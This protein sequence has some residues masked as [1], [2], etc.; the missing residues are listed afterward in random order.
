MECGANTQDGGA[1]GETGRCYSAK[2][3]CGVGRVGI[4]T[5]EEGAE[6]ERHKAIGKG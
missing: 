2:C 3:S 1:Y 4:G 5:G 6:G